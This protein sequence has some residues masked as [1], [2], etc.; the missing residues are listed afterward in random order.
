[1]IGMD[2]DISKDFILSQNRFAWASVKIGH[3]YDSLS[4]NGLNNDLGI[5][6]CQRRGQIRWCNRLASMRAHDSVIKSMITLYRI[7]RSEETRS[8]VALE[9]IAIEPAT[10]LLTQIAGNGR[11]VSNLL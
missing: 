5:Q 7:T 1:M 4:T 9:I 2:D 6:C 3:L 10:L 11:N 8:L